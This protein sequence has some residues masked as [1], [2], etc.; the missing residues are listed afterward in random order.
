M[1][2]HRLLRCFAMLL[3]SVLLHT[4]PTLAQ[5][6]AGR[7]AI[8]F[9]FGPNKYWG[10]FTDNQLWIS[11]DIYARYNI[12]S[13]L[14][15]H[16]A[17]GIGQL[18]HRNTADMIARYP[19][20]YAMYNGAIPDKSFVRTSTYEATASVNL[21][22]TQTIVPYFFAGI[23]Y[24]DFNPVRDN[25]N[26]ALPNNAIGAYSKGVL[27][28]PFGAGIE[29]YLNDN[30]TMNA[31][32]DFRLK[33]TPWLDDYNMTAQ[34][35]GS[36]EESKDDFATFGVGFSYYIL[37]NAD[38]DGDGLS[39]SREKEMG[40]DPLNPDSDGDGLTDGEEVYKT[41]TDPLRPDTDNDGLSDG[42]EVHKYGTDPLRIDSDS[43]GLTDSEEL[44]RKTNP[45]KA[46]T[47]GDG[48]L[49]GDEVNK[50]STD[51]LAIDSDGDG[52]SDGD[53]VKR[54]QTDPTKV[55]SD[56]D[57]LKDGDEVKLYLTNPKLAD[58]DGDGLS[59][60]L[61]LNQYKTDPTKI[62]SDGDGL[63]DGDEVNKYM[64]DPN[65]V[66]SDGDGLS[67]AD[68]IKKYSTNPNKVDT[69]GDGLN[70]D[71][72]I[73]KYH[74]DATKADT[75]GDG[76]KDGEEI[77][78]YHTDP[79]K[80]DT[81]GDGLSD[82]DEIMGKNPLAPLEKTNPLKAD[83]DD[84]GIADNLDYCPNVPGTDKGTKK[85]CPEGPKVGTKV[86]FPDIYFIVN[87][88]NFNYDIEGTAS[89]LAKLLSYVNQCDKLQISLE[90]H[91]SSEGP[92]KRNQVLSDLRAKKVKAWLI[93]QGVKPEKIQG[94]IGY[95]SSRPKV[96]EPDPSKVSKEELEAARKQNR[97]ITVVVVRACD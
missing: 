32:A 82:Y 89:S 97:R 5:S 2:H 6:E 44:N 61:E 47:D 24:L 64:T 52:L 55:D 19:S 14:S 45:I 54:Y 9:D 43:D 50:Y 96:K 95:G 74:T 20:Y 90:G 91:A 59:D 31:K 69:D 84:D 37:G 80:A 88:D 57:G 62:D 11:G 12:L 40:T 17:F 68:E 56:G 29:F 18:R 28:V 13:W 86:D 25:D 30:L 38:L 10:S 22:S 75:D 34:A 39:N 53:E 27:T 58:T 15:V 94:T 35:N 26:V 21:F 4:A 85:G 92:K 36:L 73:Q 49:D 87:T 8:G 77:S 71:V 76:L 78:T 67:D 16:G 83:T 72:E 63:S 81:D 60:G 3:L 93:E 46:D 70:D 33:T 42:D 66:D 41:H 79:N 23:G 7:L 51:P 48:L 65:K 1:K